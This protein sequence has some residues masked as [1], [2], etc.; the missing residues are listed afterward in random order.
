MMSTLSTRPL[1]ALMRFRRD[2]QGVAAIEF[3][4]IAPL[5]VVFLL[6]TTTATQSLWAH[7]KIAQTSSVIGDLVSQE[8]GLDDTSF[9]DILKAAPVLIE[10]FP[11]GDLTVQVTAAVACHD[12]ATPAAD[13]KP[14]MFVAWSNGWVAGTV[15]NTG[16][17]PGEKLTN[18][19]TELTIA[20]GDYI[21]KTEVNYT[22]EPT[23]SQKAGHTVAMDE[24]A[25]HQPRDQSPVT[26][27]SREGSADTRDCNKLMNR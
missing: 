3:A 9:G 10:P 11:L 24:I 16:Q 27:S 17:N 4:F 22:H 6:G 13:S 15:T 12:S 20:D 1:A 26:Y 19:P 5:L 14:T 18:A 8:T 23:I 2:E 7:G 25:Y 21:I